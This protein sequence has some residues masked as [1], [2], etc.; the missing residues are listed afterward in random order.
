MSFSQIKGQRIPIKILLSSLKKEIP[1]PSYIF[2][3]PEG[4]G[5]RLV[6]LNFA[7]MINC[8]K[9]KEE[10]CCDI[11]ISCLKIQKYNHPD[12]CWIK[13][14]DS[15]FIKIE[16]IRDLQKN[17][18]LK[19]WEAKRK[20]FI[21]CEAESLTSEAQNSL[22][23][24]L[25]EPPKENILILITSKLSLIYPTIISRCKR[26]IFSPLNSD[27]LKE[28]LIKD[29][30]LENYEA[31]FLAYFSEGRLGR[32]LELKDKRFFKEKNFIIDKFLFHTLEDFYDKEDF[33][34]ILSLLLSWFRDLLLLKRGISSSLIHTDQREKLLSLIDKYQISE[35]EQTYKIL[36]D[37]LLYKESNVNPK[38]ILNYIKVATANTAK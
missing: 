31:H 24:V 23:K 38:L 17:I 22:L 3:G 9:P 34:L 29:F 33:N 28:I 25:E 5:K 19:P 13:K 32:A 6:A 36:K 7:K 2:T 14:D 12:I 4:I 15:G 8:L 11:C 30:N 35:L 37:A 10:D 1:F 26:V 27:L 21:I 18:Y 16:P 20:I